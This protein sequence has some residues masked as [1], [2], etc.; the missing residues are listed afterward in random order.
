VT[1]SLPLLLRR[2]LLRRLRGGL[3]AAFFAAGAFAF[4][5]LFLVALASAFDAFT[6]FALTAFAAA[7][8]LPGFGS[9][10]GAISGSTPVMAPSSTTSAS[11]QITS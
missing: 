8:A 2:G 5:A 11:L 3:F 1:C 6:A 7:R 4:L 10:S 9:G